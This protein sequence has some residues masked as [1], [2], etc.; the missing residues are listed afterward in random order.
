MVTLTNNNKTHIVVVTNGLLV[1]AVPSPLFD[2]CVHKWNHL[3]SP[4]ELCGPPMSVKVG[5]PC[6]KYC[7]FSRHTRKCNCM[8]ARKEDMAVPK[9]VFYE[10][11]KVPSIMCGFLVQNLTDFGCCVESTDINWVK[12]GFQCT[13]FHETH[14]HSVI[15]CV[16]FARHFTQFGRKNAENVATISFISFS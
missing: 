12:Y 14:T 5:Q 16:L 11:Q 10:T 15:F 9:P 6:F 13:N 1:N 8:S 4:Y 7:T 3:A 2:T